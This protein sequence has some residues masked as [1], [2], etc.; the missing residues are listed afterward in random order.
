MVVYNE[1]KTSNKNQQIIQILIDHSIPHYE[2]YGDLYADSM[3][4][5]T[6]LFEKTVNISKMSKSE[7]F[8]WLGY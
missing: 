2:L 3:E 6:E 8:A 1:R 4:S 7:L 5:G